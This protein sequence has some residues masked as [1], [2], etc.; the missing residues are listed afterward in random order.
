[1]FAKFFFSDTLQ[2]RK[3][4]P[5]GDPKVVLCVKNCT[6]FDPLLGQSFS[7]ALQE[8]KTLVQNLAYTWKNENDEEIKRVYGAGGPIQITDVSSW[9][10][11]SKTIKV[12]VSG[13]ATI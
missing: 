10:L 3:Q 12:K 9:L 4:L 6:G 13:T 7:L 8:N 2:C 11:V 5:S 1:M